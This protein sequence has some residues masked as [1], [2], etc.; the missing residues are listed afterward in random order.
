MSDWITEETESVLV[1]C[2]GSAGVLRIADD[3]A[4]MLQDRFPVACGRIQWGDDVEAVQCLDLAS[5]AA[6]FADSVRRFVCCYL[7]EHEIRLPQV[8]WVMPDRARHS[9]AMPPSDFWLCAN[10]VQ[11]AFKVQTGVATV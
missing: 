10:D 6:G 1:N 7:D 8:L 3:V 9:Y 2:I 5:Q 4:K 11:K